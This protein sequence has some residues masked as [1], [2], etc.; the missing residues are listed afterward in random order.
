MEPRMRLTVETTFEAA[1]FIPG[2][3]KCGGI[4]GHTYFVTVELAVDGLDENGLT[5]DCGIVKRTIKENFDHKLLIPEDYME[6]FQRLIYESRTQ[7]KP[8]V[9]NLKPVRYTTVEGLAQEIKL[10]IDQA[11]GYE[12]VSAI[13]ISEGPTQGVTVRWF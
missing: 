3:P 5:V 11:V 6:L 9:D 12:V 8:L 7:A 13:S 2:H 10:T 1:H 4:H